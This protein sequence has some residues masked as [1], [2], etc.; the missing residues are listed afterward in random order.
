MMR[1]FTIFMAVILCGSLSAQVIWGGP[2]DPN[3]EFDGGLNDWTAI[4]VSPNEN[5]LWFWNEDGIADDGAYAGTA[6]IESPS[7]AN[8]AASFDSDF[9][10]N[11][12]VQGNFGQGL[13]AA[14]QRAELLS[15]EFSTEGFES[16]TLTWNQYMR[17]FQSTFSVEVTNDGGATW[18][19]FPIE[20]NNSVPVNSA[21]A[22]NASV[23]LNVSSAMA[24]QSAVQFKFVYEA[25][26]YFWTIDDVSVIATPDIDLVATEMYYP[27][28][29]AVVPTSFLNSDTLQFAVDARNNG[30]ADQS[31]TTAT[32]SI[33][34]ADGNA[35]FEYTQ[36]GGPVAVGDTVEIEFTDVVL[37]EDID[38]AEGD[39]TV[40][41]TVGSADGDD[42]TPGDN[43]IA[44]TVNIST[45]I[46]AVAQGLTGA[47]SFSSGNSAPTSVIR[48]GSLPDGME[49]Y[50]SIV[51]VSGADQN[52]DSI[53]NALGNIAVMKIL[54]QDGESLDPLSA[55]GNYGANGDHENL[56]VVG[57]GF[58][59]A[60][61]VD[62]FSDIPVELLDADENEGIVLDENS[63]YLMSLTWDISN[64][65]GFIFT[66]SSTRIAYFQTT[67]LVYIFEDQDMIGWYN[68]APTLAWYFPTVIEARTVDNNDI[69]ELDENVVSVFP[70]PAVDRT[71]VELEF[72]QATD[73]VI[74]LRD[75]RGG[76]IHSQSVTGV[77]NEKVEFDLSN[78]PAGS[79][80]FQITTSEN[81]RTVK[82][83]IKVN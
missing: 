10:D 78:L 24:N 26:Y 36:E 51:T 27:F 60:E 72:D 28:N 30:G 63:S 25:N 48:T 77:T 19:S 67:S 62:N 54:N 50:A 52:Q 64:N 14:P 65:G 29:A 35:V 34:D 23:S 4:A 70:N 17:Q 55:S 7:V 40:L 2:G 74:I 3:G 1:I 66:G 16:V 56:D 9:L 31:G 38:L 61:M 80:S 21:T 59:G 37:P 43:G 71:T 53:V 11:A 82:S 75:S 58:F 39:Y 6:P 68:V 20:A 73:A 8:G 46:H 44:E 15:P 45:D 57:F 79:Y 69:T 22:T 13:A 49:Y 12:G 83:L 5:A 32:V 47:N 76:Y 41:Y 42:A 81:E 18:T 33:L